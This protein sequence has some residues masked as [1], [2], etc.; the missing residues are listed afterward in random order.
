[1]K[2]KRRRDSPWNPASPVTLSPKQFEEQVNSWLRRTLSRDGVQSFTI[3]PQGTATGD[4]GEYAI[5]S[6]VSIT[7]LRGARLVILAECKHLKRP[8]ERDELLILEGKLRAVG[9]HKG[10]LFSTGGFQSGALDYAASQGIATLT[11][12]N[13][14]F[15]Y[16][17]KTAEFDA[18]PPSWVKLPDFAGIVLRATPDRIS[19]RNFYDDQLEPLWSAIADTAQA[20]EGG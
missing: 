8:V 16:E 18:E 14:R 5:D 2:D 1:M 9:A 12:V 19:S 3:E 15:M 11:V 20:I 7:L 4:G 6:L 17:T 13:G 10:M